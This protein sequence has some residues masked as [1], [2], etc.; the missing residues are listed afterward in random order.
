MNEYL[1][2]RSD[3]CCRMSC[4]TYD[5][6]L[7]NQDVEQIDSRTSVCGNSDKKIHYSA[8]YW[9]KNMKF[10]NHFDTKKERDDEI[11]KFLVYKNNDIDVDSP[12]EEG[13]INPESIGFIRKKMQ[14]LHD[15]L[16]FNG[17]SAM[18]RSKNFSLKFTR[19]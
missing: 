6:Y 18:Y 9:V 3:D 4:K 2:I 15:I 8:V 7:L 11:K 13:I 10:S 1:K 16:K 19:E 12:S 5:R 14:E 17:N